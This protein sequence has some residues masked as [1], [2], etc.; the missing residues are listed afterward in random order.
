MRKILS[1]TLALLTFVSLATPAANAHGFEIGSLKIHHPWTRATPKGADVAGGF[2][3]I[4]NTGKDDDR[5]IAITVTGVKHADIHEMA[6]ANGMMTMRPL[7]DGLAIPA[8]KTIVLKPGGFHVMMMGLN[9]P[10]NEGDYVKA[11]L[12]FEKAG[13]VDIEFVVEAQGANLKQHEM[14]HTPQ[15]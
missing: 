2:M 4:E 6:M 9:A 15:N 3:S 11:S 14:N 5:L 1:L 13:Q 8:G 7:A 12:T 10:L